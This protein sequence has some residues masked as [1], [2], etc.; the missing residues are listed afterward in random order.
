M[1]KHLRT[2]EQMKLSI[3]LY[4]LSLVF[5][6]ANKKYDPIKN[7]IMDKNATLE[8]R[9][10]DGKR[11]RSFTFKNGRIFSPLVQTKKNTAKSDAALVFGNAQTAFKTLTSGYDGDFMK[12]LDSSSLVIEG[13]AGLIFWFSST[14]GETKDLKNHTP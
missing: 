6:W 3:L 8:I 1:T 2:G 7:R 10:K 4:A 12:N 13:D 5:K 11:A 9:T 14:L